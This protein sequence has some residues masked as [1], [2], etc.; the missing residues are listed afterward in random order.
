MNTEKASTAV[1][2]AFQLLILSVIS[3]TSRAEVP[4]EGDSDWPRAVSL[5]AES[6][7]KGNPLDDGDEV[8]GLR[9]SWRFFSGTLGIEAGLGRAEPTSD[10]VR[11]LGG[12]AELLLLDVSAVWYLNYQQQERIFESG[13][14]IKPEVFVFAGPGLASLKLENRPPGPSPLDDSEVFFTLNAGIGVNIHF[15]RT[16]TF[17]EGIERRDWDRRTSRFFLRPE[18]RA[19]WFHGGGGNVDWTA[20]LALGYSFGDRPSCRSLALKVQ[21]TV[22]YAQSTGQTLR[23]DPE[24][25]LRVRSVLADLKSRVTTYGGSC[26]YLR[27]RLGST[28]DELNETLS[29]LRSGSE[30]AD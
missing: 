28:I 15:F 10:F 17:P 22:K 6:T 29:G 21:E 4:P 8:F 12:E 20:G 9:G 1:A 7:V 3:G 24:E 14:P 26:S 11:N 2:I 5:F 18:V 16:K 30:G 27:E 19:R 13:Y 23:S 25:V